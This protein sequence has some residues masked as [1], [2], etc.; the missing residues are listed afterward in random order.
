MG[1]T[2]VRDVE[3]FLRLR[4]TE[5]LFFLTLPYIYIYRHAF[6]LSKGRMRR[7]RRNIDLRNSDYG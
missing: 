1:A 4:T 2:G 3:K 5:N 6:H 7:R